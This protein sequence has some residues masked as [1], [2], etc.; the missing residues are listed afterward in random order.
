M[1]LPKQGVKWDTLDGQMD[2]ARAGDVDWRD[3]RIGVYIHYAGDD[4]LQ[5][6]K[7]AYL[8]FFSENG[9]G[10]KAFPSLAK[11]EREVVS[12]TLALLNAPAQAAGSMTT[13][14]TESIFLAVKAARDWARTV[15]PEVSS[16]E[17]VAPRSAHPAFDKAAH[18]LG[19]RVRRVPVADG[20]GA[21]PV[22]M[23]AAIGSNT[24]MLIGSAPAYPYGVMDPIPQL[25]AIAVRAGLWLH[26]DACVGGFIAPFARKLGVAM[27]DFDFSVPGVRSISADLHKYGYA[28][29]GASTV[30]YRDSA[31][32]AFQP[33]EFDDWPR[34][35]YATQTLVGTRAGGAIAAAWAVMNFLGEEGYLDVT[36][37]VLAIRQAIENGVSALGFEVWGRPQLSIVAYG[38][39][40]DDIA[41]IANH[42][43]DRSWFVGQIVEPPGIHLM[44]N[45]THEPAVG[46]YLADLESART[47]AR[48]GRRSTKQVGA[49]Y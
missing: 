24:I 35:K 18:F 48:Q 37:R 16:P 44:L 22:A 45:L 8:K 26:V 13:G 39:P 21:D 33:Y 31:S 25:G 14:G 6:A 32:F 42:L 9:L 4:V 17:I 12:M 49:T 20:F 29:K 7:N 2:A 5:V 34:G 30:L 15:R 10:P 28:A 27:P 3:G 23:E 46:R 40:E 41:A 47:A 11:F 38:S 36:R 19:L 1:Q 43:A